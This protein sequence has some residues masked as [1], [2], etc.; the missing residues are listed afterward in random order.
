MLLIQND[1]FLFYVCMCILCVYF[2]KKQN[3]YIQES[4]AGDDYK[5]TLVKDYFLSEI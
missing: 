5:K 3:L 2:Y 1:L 4:V